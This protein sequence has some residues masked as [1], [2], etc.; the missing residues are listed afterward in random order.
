MDI[1]SWLTSGIHMYGYWVILAAVALE[2]MG[3]PFP[4]E[5]ALLAGAIFA[6]TGDLNIVLVIL[7]ASAGAILGDNLGYTIGHR[8]GYHCCSALGA[9][10][11]WICA[12]CATPSDSSNDMATRPS[13]SAA[14]F[15]SCAPMSR[16]S[17]ASTVCRGAHS[18]C[19]MHWA[20]SHGRSFSALWATSWE[21]RPLC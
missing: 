15:Q 13:S 1:P 11:T 3:V 8:G 20:A 17:R 4:G 2:S 19:S 16:C 10:F 9:C 18:W 5:T 7:A 14:S 21:S 6:G 12:A